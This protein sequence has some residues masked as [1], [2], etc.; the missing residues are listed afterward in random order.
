MQFRDHFW[1]CSE[2][3]QFTTH[4]S[5]SFHVPKVKPPK[6][7]TDKKRKYICRAPRDL[8]RN[9][10]SFL[11][12]SKLSQVSPLVR[13]LEAPHRAPLKEVKPLHVKETNE[14]RL[15]AV[16]C[17]GLLFPEIRDYRENTNGV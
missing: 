17:G 9:D 15:N 6:K 8:G 16:L 10:V 1:N 7:K 12:F 11:G 5:L 14:N 4:F 3:A 2:K 13:L